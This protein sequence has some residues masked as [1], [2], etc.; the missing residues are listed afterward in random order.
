MKYTCLIIDDE[1][2]SQFILKKFISEV[3]F[4]ELKGICNNANEALQCIKAD[5]RIDLLFLDIN[6]PRISGLS[7][8]KSL[9]NAPIVIF[10]TAYSEFAVEAFEVNALDYLLKPFSFDRFLTAVNKIELKEIDN[11]TKIHSNDFILIK[12]NKVVHKVHFKDLIFIEASGDYVNLYLNGETIKTNTTFSA[13]LT[14]LPS[15]FFVRTH[16]SFAVNNSKIK[17]VSANQVTTLNHKIPIGL[18]YRKE[19]IVFLE[20]NKH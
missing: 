11:E 20:R 13:M 8:Y 2:S 10:T 5:N 17:S 15:E 9:K 3:N 18:K 14:A 16:K 1:P 19:F 4:L 7:F 6:M 12:S